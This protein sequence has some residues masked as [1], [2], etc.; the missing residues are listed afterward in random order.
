MKVTTFQATCS[1]CHTRF[2]N[3]LLPDMSYGE[4]IARGEKGTAFAYLPSI[5]N[6]GWDRINQL[7]KKVFPKKHA[8][9]ETDC[10]Q[11][12]IG[13]CLDPINDQNLR[14]V[15]SPV[16]PNCQGH[17]VQYGDDVR[18]GELDLPDATFSKFLSLDDPAQEQMIKELCEQW[19]GTPT[20][21]STR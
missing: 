12:M 19:L 2:D 18:T 13:K 4:F 5:G 6:A 10:F 14:I 8:S 7:F 9:S 3:P 1:D 11:W 16:C 21:S 17:N 20:R 15:G